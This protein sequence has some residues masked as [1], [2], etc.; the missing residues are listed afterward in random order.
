MKKG[1]LKKVAVVAFALSALFM[2]NVTAVYASEATQ[3]QGRRGGRATSEHELRNDWN[4]RESLEKLGLE[5]TGNRERTEREGRIF[6]PNFREILD[7]LDFE[8][9]NTR[10]RTER[11]LRIFRFRSTAEI[12]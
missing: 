3:E 6:L 11:E 12:E 8:R 7:E 1:F 10:T 4:I 2:F 9:S 5:R